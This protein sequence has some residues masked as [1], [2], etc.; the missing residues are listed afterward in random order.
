MTPPDAARGTR[1]GPGMAE[2]FVAGRPVPLEEA[3][4]AAS[5][6]LAR[7][8]LPVLAGLSTD[9]AGVQEALRLG[10]V[11]GGVVDH[12]HADA[13]LRDLGVMRDSGWIVTTP[14]QARARADLLLLVGPGL[15]EAW[16][17]ITERLLSVAPDGAESARRIIRLCPG[18]GAG[19][20]AS[21]A[22]TIGTVAELLPRLSALRALVAGR[23][24]QGS[25]AQL[26]GL[27][28]CAEALRAARYGVAVW[29]AAH[30]DPLAI[31]MLCGLIE[32]LN[33]HT[34]FAGLP[35]APG[36]NAAGAAQ[37]AGW[38][39]G[40]P[41]PVGFGRGVPEHDPW[42]FSA[43]RLVES[44]EADAVLWISACRPEPPPWHGLPVVALT[45]PGTRFT[46]PPEVAITV[47]R[48][49]I[50]HDAVMFDPRI[51]G[52]AA[53]AAE[54]PTA[55]PR[56]AEVLARLSDLAAKTGAEALPC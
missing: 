27:A 2:A 19:E 35:L 31:A 46:A 18:R 8:R 39:T 4:D 53:C 25:A 50:D 36:D 10:R 40:F 45:A 48:P 13:M 11:L 43:P 6:L 34:R 42:R 21:G 15:G 47:G 56:V 51:G 41:L 33:A 7:S 32:D 9:I 20:V 3:L 38:L 24:V 49:G 23:T 37:A 26:R 14:L 1:A 29:S 5:G 52:L 17:E 44:G 54:A 55:A 22:E 30:L 28:A 16:P 12:M